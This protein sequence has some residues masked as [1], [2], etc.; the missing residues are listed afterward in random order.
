MLS[1]FIV[2]ALESVSNAVQLNPKALPTALACS[3]PFRDAKVVK[4]VAAELPDSEVSIV[5]EGAYE[6]LL[7]VKLD[8]IGK[9]TA[10]RVA[11]SSGRLA[12]DRAAEAAA[13]ASTY[14]PKVVRCRAVDTEVVWVS[15][16]GDP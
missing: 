14:S 9:P 15:H 1:L 7:L 16:F 11:R 2:V 5:R 10:I 3:V 6:T 12:L 4:A 8:A 13:K